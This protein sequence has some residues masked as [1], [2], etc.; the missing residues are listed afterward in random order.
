MASAIEEA[1][2]AI[3]DELTDAG[4]TVET[5]RNEA[6]ILEQAEFPVVALAWLGA[7][8]DRIDQCGNHFWRAQVALD[9][10]AKVETGT[11]VVQQ[12]NAMVATA[13]AALY[14]R[15]TADSFGGLFHDLT[16]I[17]V[18][19]FATIGADTGCIVL[20]LAVQFQTAR[21]DWTRILTD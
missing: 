7:E 11:S 9:C 2:A 4:L 10:W 15:Q 19:D 1:I 12:C 18:S 16:P 17:T 13:Q 21:G 3:K 20:T 6:D 8:I 5:E 14:A